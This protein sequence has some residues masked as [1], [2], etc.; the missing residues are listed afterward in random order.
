M[1]DKAQLRQALYEATTRFVEEYNM[2]NNSMVTAFMKGLEEIENED[3]DILIDG[4]SMHGVFYIS[5]L[6]D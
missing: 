5:I 4:G 3:E 1:L 2:N 6:E